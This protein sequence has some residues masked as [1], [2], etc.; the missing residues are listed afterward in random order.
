M[1]TVVLP[2]VH[3]AAD[4][5]N[6]SRHIPNN[7]KINIIASVESA[8]ALWAIAD[9][10]S[11]H[12]D[13]MGLVAPIT[14]FVQGHTRRWAMGWS[15]GTVRLPD[16]GLSVAVDTFLSIVFAESKEYLLHYSAS[17]IPCHLS[18]TALLPS[19]PLSISTTLHQ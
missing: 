18:C 5:T 8:R 6:I 17:H 11:W 10:A 12:S 1:K 14:E 15:F 9:I 2:K 16:V 3:S 13:N 19:P 4:L 7:R